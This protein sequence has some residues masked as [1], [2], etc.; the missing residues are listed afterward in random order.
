MPP[1]KTASKTAPKAAQ[2]KLKPAQ[3]GLK[4]ASARGAVAERSNGR[5]NRDDELVDRITG[6]WGAIVVERIAADQDFAMAFERYRSAP[7][8]LRAIFAWDEVL[9]AEAHLSLVNG[10]IARHSDMP[11]PKRVR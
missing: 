2:R 11:M 3:R 4:A 8:D 1:T 5:S 7:K 9:S 6:A 10:I